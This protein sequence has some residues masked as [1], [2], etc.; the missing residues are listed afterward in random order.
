MLYFLEHVLPMKKRQ[1]ELY[2]KIGDFCFS[3]NESLIQALTLHI[4]GEMLNEKRLVYVNR[5]QENGG[6]ISKF[7]EIGNKYEVRTYI[8]NELSP[9]R[10]DYKIM[11]LIVVGVWCKLHRTNNV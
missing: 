2:K 1:N 9:K 4:I 11:L 8:R 6:L 7:R 3:A 5:L 10:L